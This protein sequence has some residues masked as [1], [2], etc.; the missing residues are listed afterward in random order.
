[1]L[2]ADVRHSRS[3]QPRRRRKSRARSTRETADLIARRKSGTSSLYR[4]A[5]PGVH[6]L[7]AGIESQLSELEAVLGS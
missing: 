2:E 6:E 4:I 7:C 5:D 3:S 1:M